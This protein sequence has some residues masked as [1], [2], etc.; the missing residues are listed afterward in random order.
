MKYTLG[1]D[2]CGTWSQGE[3]TLPYA[4]IVAVLG[5]PTDDGDG[6][7][8]ST[9]WALKFEDGTIATLYDWKETEL[10]DDGLETVEEFRERDSYAWHIG[11][12]TQRA[13]ELIREL[14]AEAQH[15]AELA[16]IEAI[17]F[18]EVKPATS[19]PEIISHGHALQVLS[20]VRELNAD[21]LAALRELLR[22][23]EANATLTSKTLKHSAAEHAA[24]AAIAKAVQS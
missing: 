12:T 14:F 3:I 11:G 4:A 10:Y 5:E 17:D 13:V 24:R 18:A 19:A 22:Q 20:N 16:R 7:K 23:S 8:V 9:H 6:Y 1:A 21:L 15:A 2:S